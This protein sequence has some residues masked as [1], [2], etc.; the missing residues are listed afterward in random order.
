MKCKFWGTPNLVSVVASEIENSLKAACT[1]LFPSPKATEKVKKN[2]LLKNPLYFMEELEPQG[3][4]R[5]YCWIP[6]DY[7]LSVSF[8]CF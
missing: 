7:G 1:T 3:T 8:V 4:Q 5:Y 2:I 6:M